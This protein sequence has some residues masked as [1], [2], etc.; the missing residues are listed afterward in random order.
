MPQHDASGAVHYHHLSAQAPSGVLERHSDSTNL[1]TNY[2][3]K[4]FRND[5][6]SNLGIK[7]ALF[8]VF[9]FPSQQA[10]ALSLERECIPYR[11]AS[12]HLKFQGIPAFS[13]GIIN[14]RRKLEYFEYFERIKIRSVGLSSN[15]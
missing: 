4:K 7:L 5:I 11:V 1:C 12:S 14:S 9:C 8:V 10:L 3:V 15:K 13:L 2:H 6:K